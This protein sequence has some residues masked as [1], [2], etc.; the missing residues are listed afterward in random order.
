VAHCRHCP[1]TDPESNGGSERIRPWLP[2]CSPVGALLGV[3]DSVII[4]GAL[5]WGLPLM[6]HR[7]TPAR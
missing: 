4:T 1:Y 5:S 3:A 7:S 6:G 2:F